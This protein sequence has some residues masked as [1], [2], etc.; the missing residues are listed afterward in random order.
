MGLATNHHLQLADNT[1]GLTYIM[2]QI[3]KAQTNWPLVVKE[4]DIC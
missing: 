3:T 2:V 1:I 4:W